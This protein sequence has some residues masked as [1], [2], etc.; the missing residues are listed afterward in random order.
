MGVAVFFLVMGH[1]FAG[2]YTFA[3]V[4]ALI[5]VVLAGRRPEHGGGLRARSSWNLVPIIAFAVAY[6][7][8]WF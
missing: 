1:S 3:A 4:I 7:L 2:T 5:A 8:T 6:Y